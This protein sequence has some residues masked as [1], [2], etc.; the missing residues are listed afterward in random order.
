MRIA[1]VLGPKFED[2]E[3]KQ[4]YDAFRRA[5]HEVTVVGMETGAQIEGDKGT[6]KAT[7]EKSFQDVKPGAFAALLIPGGGNPVK[8]RAH[9]EAVGYVR[10]VC[11]LSTPAIPN[12]HG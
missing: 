5:G 12:A 3:F 6:V 8:L 4:P 2:S 9:A 7:V 11:P 10:A 1:C